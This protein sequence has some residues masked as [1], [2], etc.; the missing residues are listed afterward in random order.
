MIEFGQLKQ[1]LQFI[2]QEIVRFKA[3]I[4]S[5]KKDLLTA[6]TLLE[7]MQ[8]LCSR[9]THMKANLPSHLPRAN[10]NPSVT[11]VSPEQVVTESDKKNKTNQEKVCSEWEWSLCFEFFAFGY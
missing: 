6:H 1:E 9:L 11:K 5:S 2:R 4:S 3:I 8:E 10:A 7:L